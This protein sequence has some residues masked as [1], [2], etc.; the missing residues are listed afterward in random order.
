MLKYIWSFSLRCRI[1]HHCGNHSF[2][3][4]DDGSEREIYKKGI[5]TEFVGEAQESHDAV[6]AVLHGQ[7]QLAYISPESLLG[8]P[9]FRSMSLSESYKTRLRGV[10]VDEAHCVKLW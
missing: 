9:L 5:S 4:T 3:V 10:V 8:N 7:K 2:G 6:A 1:N